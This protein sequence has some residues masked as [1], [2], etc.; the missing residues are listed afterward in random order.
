MAKKI[1]KEE[2]VTYSKRELRIA[3]LKNE[4]IN[5]KYLSDL[6]MDY[7]LKKSLDKNH[8]MSN[9]LAEIV[10]VMIEKMIGSPSWRNYTPDY[11][12]EFRG[13]AVEHVIRY[14]HNF[15][16]EKCKKGKDDAFNYFAMIIVNAFIQSLKKCKSYSANNIHINHDIIY[17]EQMWNGDNVMRVEAEEL[18]KEQ[19][20]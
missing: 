5:T 8:S 2:P 12:E 15:S 16:P 11:K 19:N 13:R 6:V 9:E 10:L 1:T 17:N 18:T 7:K 14:A 20:S 4:R 3:K